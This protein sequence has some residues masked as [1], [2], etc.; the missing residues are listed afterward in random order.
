MIKVYYSNKVYRFYDVEVAKNFAQRQSLVS[1]RVSVFV[2]D[3]MLV[4]YEFGK[5]VG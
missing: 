1:F 4:K 5:V 2:N 3:V